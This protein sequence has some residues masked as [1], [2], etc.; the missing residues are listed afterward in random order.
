MLITVGIYRQ[1]L[2]KFSTLC[3]ENPVSSSCIIIT[4]GQTS[5]YS[6]TKKYVYK[7]SYKGTKME[8]LEK[9]SEH[10]V[11][12]N[13]VKKNVGSNTVTKKQPTMLKR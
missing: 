6:Q 3:F 13:D 5:T 10:F 7:F 12:H 1:S 4:S 2:L 11:Y 9:N 8:N